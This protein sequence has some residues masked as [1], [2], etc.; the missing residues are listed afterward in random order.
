MWSVECGVWSTNSYFLGWNG[1]HLVELQRGRDEWGLSLSWWIGLAVFTLLCFVAQQSVQVGIWGWGLRE[2]W[3]FMGGVWGCN[4]FGI[5]RKKIDYVVEGSDHYVLL[6]WCG[7]IVRECFDFNDTRSK[8]KV[9][10]CVEVY[11]SF[12]VLLVFNGSMSDLLGRLVSVCGKAT[13]SKGWRRYNLCD[14]CSL[15]WRSSTMCF[16]YY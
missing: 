16:H 10:V 11:P 14:A 15:Q 2:G 1:R 3:G 5:G 8:Q 4:E 7:F 6:R 13:G 9:V 12:F